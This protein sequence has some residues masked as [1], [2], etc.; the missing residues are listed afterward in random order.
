MSDLPARPADYGI[1]APN[2]VRTLS[3]AGAAALLIS[4]RPNT[5]VARKDVAA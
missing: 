3:I 5:I 4:L 2:V 1:D